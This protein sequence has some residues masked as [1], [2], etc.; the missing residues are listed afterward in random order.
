MEARM[1][2]DAKLL[3]AMAKAIGEVF[4]GWD[5]IIQEGDTCMPKIAQAAL[6]AHAEFTKGKVTEPILICGVHHL[7]PYATVK[8]HC[9][10]CQLATKTAELVECEEVV[11]RLRE[12][13]TTVVG[14]AEEIHGEELAK[15]EKQRVLTKDILGEHKSLPLTVAARR[16]L[17]RADKAEARISEFKAIAVPKGCHIDGCP[18]T[19]LQAI[20]K[21]AG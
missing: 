20:A 6:T 11:G 7:A 5:W 15:Y 19:K 18:F 10:V 9:P 17:D 14:E 16:V 4:K 21:G 3:E 12:S 2:D 1:T 13:L 8:D